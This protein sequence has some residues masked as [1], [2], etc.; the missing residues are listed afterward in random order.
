[1]LWYACSRLFYSAKL[2]ISKF[3]TVVLV[4]DVELNIGKKNPKT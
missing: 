4:T 1:M 2:N 3:S